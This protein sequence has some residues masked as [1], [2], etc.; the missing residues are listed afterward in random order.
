M[1][2]NKNYFLLVLLCLLQWGCLSKPKA[3]P[4]IY[5]VSGT[6]TMETFND[7]E[8]KVN[9]LPIRTVV[10]KDC[11]GG[12]SLAGIR[13]GQEIKKNNIK[14]VVSGTAAS[15]CAYA[16]L[17]GVIRHVDASSKDNAVVLHGGFDAATLKPLDALKNQ[18]YL[19]LHSR[20]LGFKFSKVATD[21]ILNT[22]SPLE[23]IYY[24]R[25]YED[26]K[27]HDLTF[28]CDASNGEIDFKKCQKL[29]GITLES[30]GIITK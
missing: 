3:D 5:T 2:R 24:L 19:D 4:S 21:I 16:Y 18:E 15:A 27:V 13:L 8:K 11:F 25:L 6:L 28:Y 9:T 22:K 23:G 26:N 12:I 14:T 30:E 10:F 1:S 20:I 7:F 17:G 29:E